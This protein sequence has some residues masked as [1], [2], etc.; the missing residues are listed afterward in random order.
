MEWWKAFVPRQPVKR[1]K[2]KDTLITEGPLRGKS[3]F[4][5]LKVQHANRWRLQQIRDGESL[6]SYSYFTKYVSF[7]DT[8][9]PEW[10]SNIQELQKEKLLDVVKWVVNFTGKARPRFRSWWPF[11]GQFRIS[12]SPVKKPLPILESASRTWLQGWL[13]YRPDRP[14]RCPEAESRSSEDL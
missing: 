4:E 5:C 1:L 3:L 2:K 10:T 7:G 12:R 9:L 8:T 14:R 11:W 6:F 13:A